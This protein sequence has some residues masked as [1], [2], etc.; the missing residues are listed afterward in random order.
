MSTATIDIP[1]IETATNSTIATEVPTDDTEKNL[2]HSSIR[3]EVDK[4]DQQKHH[5]NI[6]KASAVSEV[7]AAI[8]DTSSSPTTVSMND[9]N[10]NHSDSSTE[11]E[12]EKINKLERHT[13]A[14]I[15]AFASS[16]VVAVS[17]S[18]TTSD[19][20]ENHSN[21][22][23]KED[24]NR[25]KIPKRHTCNQCSRSFSRPSKLLLHVR[26]VHE[27]IRDHVCVEC[28]KRYVRLFDLQVHVRS[29]TG[30]HSRQT[31]YYG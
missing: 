1:V 18:N 25:K 15:D 20:E 6:I 28:G 9:D 12:P 27:G 8:S 5:S 13:H 31:L 21:N 26:D 24:P 19:V 17:T 16:A 11:K 3:K 4:I 22:S 2:S 23:T 10:E 14:S 7:F 29:H 30:K